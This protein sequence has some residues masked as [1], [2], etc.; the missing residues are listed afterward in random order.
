MDQGNLKLLNVVGS[1]KKLA[2]TI[3]LLVVIAAGTLLVYDLFIQTPINLPDF[4]DDLVRITLIVAFWLTVLVVISRSKHTI[5]KQLGD[6]PATIV[7]FLMLSISLLIMAFAVLHV[8]GVSPD[9]LLAGAGIASITIGLIVSTFVGSIL[10]GVFVFASHRYR[11]GDNVF[12]NNAPGRIVD[13]SAIVTRVR[14]DIGILTLPNSAIASG[15]VIVTKIHP[16]EMAS[17]SRLPYMQGDR[18]VTTYMQGEGIVTEIA[19]LHTKVA[20]DSGRELTFLNSSVL[21]GTI[22]IARVGQNSSPRQVTQ[23]EKRD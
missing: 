20:L 18:I 23:L 7:T 1:V 22:A 13:I 16:H 15:T 19:P 14:T 10:S 2:V 3:F 11:V 6:Q 12:V 8:V 21:A 17:Y 9:A 5:A 4:A